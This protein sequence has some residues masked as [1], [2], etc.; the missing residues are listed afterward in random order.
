MEHKYE[1]PNQVNDGTDDGADGGVGGGTS[2]C[3][4]I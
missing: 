1:N 4:L 2:G 3:G